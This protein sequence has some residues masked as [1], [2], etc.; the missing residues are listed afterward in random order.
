MKRL[1]ET[2]VLLRFLPLVRLH[3][4]GE[5]ERNNGRASLVTSRQYRCDC[6]ESSGACPCPMSTTTI[7]AVMEAVKLAANMPGKRGTGR[8]NERGSCCYSWMYGVV[9][10]F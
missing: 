8:G 5:F 6:Y 1:V 9:L 4:F 7:K 2:R 3:S 10:R